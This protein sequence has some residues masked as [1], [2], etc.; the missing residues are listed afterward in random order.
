MVARVC[1]HPMPLQRF[2][3]PSPRR[4]EAF[5]GSSANDCSR[6]ISHRTAA[7]LAGGKRLAVTSSAVSQLN[8]ECG[9]VVDVSLSRPLRKSI[10]PPP[11]GS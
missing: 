3:P 10:R 11:S 8:G 9:T 2:P 4:G 5:A 7:A 1:I 6:C